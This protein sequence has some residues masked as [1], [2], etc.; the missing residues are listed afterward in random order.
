[1]SLHIYFKPRSLM[2]L[3]LTIYDDLT[4]YRERD[5]DREKQ[6]DPNLIIL[7]SDLIIW[8]ET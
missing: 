5:R 6:S 1:M 3:Y 4:I 2:I 7:F 8:G